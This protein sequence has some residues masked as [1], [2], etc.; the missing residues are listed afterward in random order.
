MIARNF[1]KINN[2]LFYISYTILIAHYILKSIT[3]FDNK[4]NTIVYAIGISVLILLSIINILEKGL[5]SSTIVI[6]ISIALVILCILTH[7]L[8]LPTIWLLIIAFGKKDFDKLVEYDIVIKTAL[9]L[10]VVTL[11]LVGVLNIGSTHLR[12]E[13]VRLSLGFNNPNMFST[14]V[15]SIVFEISYLRR[16]QY[17][18]L[19]I[20]ISLVAVLIIFFTTGSRTQIACI[21]LSVILL[22]IYKKKPKLF[23][24]KT[25][26]WIGNNLFTIIAAI[27]LISLCIY[28][29]VPYSS[30]FLNTILPDRIRLPANTIKSTG[31]W[32]FGNITYAN[33]SFDS[34][35]DNLPLFITIV[36]GIIPLVG[37]CFLIKQYMKGL[38][39]GTTKIIY[40]I[41]VVFILSCF[42][43]KICFRP[44][45]NI[46]ILYAATLLFNNTNPTLAHQEKRRNKK[47]D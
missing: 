47:N 6:I 32:L 3:F 28:F 46:F 26:N 25:I 22:L 4:I 13:T 29:L 7:D 12:G 8:L 36:Y 24:G 39:N 34:A 2:I 43:E 44:Q 42:S 41:M 18:I 20:I 31:L 9:V 15:L 1:R 19:E 27:S 21:I 45:Y 16:K 5:K 35:L 17:G 11:S 40:L 14:Y 30:G 10:L 37:T 23:S 38:N 33:S